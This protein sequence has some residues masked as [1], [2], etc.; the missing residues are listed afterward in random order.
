MNGV[1]SVFTTIGVL[2]SIAAAAA[3]QPRAYARAGERS[4]SPA[5]SPSR[6]P[7]VAWNRQ[8]FDRSQAVVLWNARFH[9]D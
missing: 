7:R 8:I 6:P 9:V 3:G 4:S 5:I 1:Q 2:T